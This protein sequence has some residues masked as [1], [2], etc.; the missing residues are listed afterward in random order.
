MQ[1]LTRG[2]KSLE[3]ANKVR[4]MRCH[5]AASRIFVTRPYPLPFLALDPSPSVSPHPSGAR[6][7]RR[8]YSAHSVP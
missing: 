4:L 6:G 5:E 2:E 3:G 8:I 7:R 1:S